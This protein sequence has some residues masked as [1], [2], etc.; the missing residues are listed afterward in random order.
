MHFLGRRK[1]H[2]RKFASASAFLRTDHR[3][4]LQ[5]ANPGPIADGGCPVNSKKARPGLSKEEMT[6]KVQKANRRRQRISLQLVP[7]MGEM[8]ETRCTVNVY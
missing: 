6:A 2:W 7:W 5:I 4:G 3:H 1:P 8:C